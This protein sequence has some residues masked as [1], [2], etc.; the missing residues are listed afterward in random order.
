MDILIHSIF[1]TSWKF[2]VAIPFTF[3]LEYIRQLS[4]LWWY[5]I[6]VEVDQILNNSLLS[7]ILPPPPT[8]T[9]KA[10]H[11]VLEQAKELGNWAGTSWLITN[12]LKE[13]CFNPEWYLFLPLLIDTL[14]FCWTGHDVKDL[15]FVSFV[16]KSVFSCRMT[17]WWRKSELFLVMTLAAEGYPTC[18]IYP[19]ALCL[20]KFYPWHNLYTQ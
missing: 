8:Q 5:C 3:S 11:I 12:P 4:R 15:L 14:L 9:V 20:V 18:H 1:G 19:P 16:L 2:Y 17:L 6:V 13:I 7:S 10:D